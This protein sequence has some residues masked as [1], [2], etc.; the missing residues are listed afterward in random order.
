LAITAQRPVEPRPLHN[1]DGTLRSLARQMW[2]D[3]PVDRPPDEPPR[4]KP[5]GAEHVTVP[6]MT[7]DL[8]LGR[9]I[10]ALA[11]QSPAARQ[12]AQPGALF[13]SASNPNLAYWQRRSEADEDAASASED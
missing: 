9:L 13:E 7:L 5:G 12:Q 10:A 1:E 6:T 4:L 8:L 3:L 2:L 11:D